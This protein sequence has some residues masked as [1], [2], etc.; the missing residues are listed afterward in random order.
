MI[1]PLVLGPVL[2]IGKSLI[3]RFFPDKEKAAEAEREFLKMAVQGELTQVMAQLE[4]NAK[5]ASHASIWVAGWRPFF[6]W[7][8]GLGFAFSAIAQPAL[9]WYG[10]SRGWPPPPQLDMELLWVVI[11]GMLGIGGLRTWE[12]NKGLTK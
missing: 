3:E 4:I 8:G 9:A 5:E 6:G 11:T 7:V 1:N 10:T 12:K 2:E